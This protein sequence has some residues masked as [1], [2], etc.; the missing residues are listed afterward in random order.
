[1][2]YQ[3]FCW[4]LF[5]PHA[6]SRTLSASQKQRLRASRRLLNRQKRK[7]KRKNQQRLPRQYPC[8]HLFSWHRSLPA[9]QPELPALHQCGKQT[10]SVGTETDIGEAAFRRAIAKADGCVRRTF[11]SHLIGAVVALAAMI[12][13]IILLIPR[14]KDCHQSPWNPARTNCF[15]IQTTELG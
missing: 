5:C 9:E 7:R 14:S 3:Y 6:H 12:I 2:C 13:A 1:M 15:I 11:Q 8:G 10:E 4:D